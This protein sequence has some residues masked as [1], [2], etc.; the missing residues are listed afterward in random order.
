M[1]YSIKIVFCL[2]FTSK[3]VS[4]VFVPHQY[5][6]KKNKRGLKLQEKIIFATSN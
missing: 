6:V 1:L 3:K 2:L 5:F 4:I